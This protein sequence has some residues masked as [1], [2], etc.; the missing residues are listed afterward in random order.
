MPVEYVLNGILSCLSFAFDGLVYPS[1]D[2]KEENIRNN[3]LKDH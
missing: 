1:R 2:G 3:Y